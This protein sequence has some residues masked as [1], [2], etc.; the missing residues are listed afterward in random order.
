[1]SAIALLPAQSIDVRTCWWG[2]VEIRTEGER[3]VVL[4]V[5]PKG[6]TMIAKWGSA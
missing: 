6:G 1:M 3:V 2:H 4:L 5:L